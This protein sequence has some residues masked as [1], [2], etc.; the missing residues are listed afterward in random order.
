[1]SKEPGVFSEHIAPP[2]IG[3]GI[4]AA[5]GGL[6][7]AAGGYGA[8]SI[9]GALLQKRYGHLDPAAVT[10]LVKALPSKTKAV[11]MGALAVGA[12]AGLGGLAGGVSRNT[13]P[14]AA[15]TAGGVAGGVGGLGLG[16]LLRTPG[17]PVSSVVKALA[18]GA[19]GAGA[20]GMT[21]LSVGAARRGK[22]EQ[23]VR[24]LL[25]EAKASRAG[26]QEEGQ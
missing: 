11:L 5:G 22:A 16:Y 18:L 14:Y 7:G 10:A 20:G 1:M 21:G 25:E 19:L 8:I 15:R 6:L 24:Q 13:A 3:A 2:L 26:L 17:S 12:P 23:K 4:G 9:E